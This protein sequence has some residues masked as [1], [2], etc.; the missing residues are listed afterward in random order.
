MI[1]T[2]YLIG[3][4]VAGVLVL[5]PAEARAQDPDTETSP[6]GPAVDTELVF[7]REVFQYPE[8]TRRNPFTAFAGGTSRGPRF[9]RL[10]LIGLIYSPEGNSVAVLSTGGVAVAE[11]G[12]TSPIEGDAYSM[13][14]GDSI[15]NTTIVEV[16]RDAVIVDVQVFDAVQSHIMTFVSRLQGGTP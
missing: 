4:S 9:E 5:A 13:K 6:L 15:G 11:D 3:I 14:V 16:R 8:W 7:D 12:T 10:S 2:R 1:L